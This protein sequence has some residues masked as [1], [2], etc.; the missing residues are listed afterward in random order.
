MF[1][2]SESF[3]EDKIAIEDDMCM[4]LLMAPHLYIMML[5]SFQP[6][7]LSKENQIS[8]NFLLLV[9]DLLGQ[10]IDNPTQFRDLNFFH[11]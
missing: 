2:S 6:I 9:N 1:E 8:I 10:L 11:S 5:N 4:L 7:E 3:D